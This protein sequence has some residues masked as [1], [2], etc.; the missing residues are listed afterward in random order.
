[1]HGLCVA[2][3]PPGH[4]ENVAVAPA[5]AQCHRKYW[6]NAAEWLARPA[7]ARAQNYRVWGAANSYLP[8]KRGGRRARLK[9]GEA[10]GD[11]LRK[12]DPHPVTATFADASVA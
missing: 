2:T 6:V 5:V 7:S 8:L 9:P 11:H 1:M 3:P 4:Q 12:V 10:G